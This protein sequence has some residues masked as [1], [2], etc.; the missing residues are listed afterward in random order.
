ML[1]YLWA[2]MMLVGVL[3]GA[4]HGNLNGVTDGALTSAKDAVMLCIT[5]LGIMSF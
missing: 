2:F 3:W 1:N 5:M 4:F